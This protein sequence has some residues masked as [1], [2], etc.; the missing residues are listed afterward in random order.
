[1][2]GGSVGFG[3][4]TKTNEQFMESLIKYI[5]DKEFATL[6]EI[7]VEYMSKPKGK[8]TTYPYGNCG[9]WGGL[10]PTKNQLIYI[11]KLFPFTTNKSFI[12]KTPTRFNLEKEGENLWSLT[13]NHEEDYL[14]FKDKLIK[15]Y[16][17][18]SMKKYHQSGGKERYEAK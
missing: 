5:S 2:V 16:D 7:Y 12:L 18:K 13:E 4:L 15:K 6:K 8:Y 17:I 9:R 1:M 10:R 3:V 14:K 11:L